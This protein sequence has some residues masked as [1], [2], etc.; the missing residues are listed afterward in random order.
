MTPLN[1]LV[2]DHMA[3]QPKIIHDHM[4]CIIFYW[5]WIPLEMLLYLRKHDINSCE[6]LQIINEDFKVA[7]QKINNLTKRIKFQATIEQDLP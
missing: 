3:A 1:Q 7:Q 4:E 6:L 5:G 2:F